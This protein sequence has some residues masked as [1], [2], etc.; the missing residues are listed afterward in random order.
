MTCPKSGDLPQVT[1]DTS[2]ISYNQNEMAYAD[3][4]KRTHVS[5]F[6]SVVFELILKR[7]DESFE[8]VSYEHEPEVAMFAT[9]VSQ[10]GV[11]EETAAAPGSPVAQRPLEDDVP[12]RAA[13]LADLTVHE[14]DTGHIDCQHG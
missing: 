4:P 2:P 3:K 13:R 6:E 14:P 5:V 9:S 1:T 7:R 10:S 11:V 12:R 8:R